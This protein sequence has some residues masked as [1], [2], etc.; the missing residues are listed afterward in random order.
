MFLSHLSVSAVFL[1]FMACLSWVALQTPFY[2]QNQDYLKMYY[3]S[4][5][6]VICNFYTETNILA[7]VIKIGNWE[8]L[9]VLREYGHLTWELV[10]PAVMSFLAGRVEQP[11]FPRVCPW[12]YQNIQLAELADN[13]VKLSLLS[14]C[15]FF[16]ILFHFFLHCHLQKENISLLRFSEYDFKIHLTSNFC[17]VSYFMVLVAYKWV[18]VFHW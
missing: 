7:R 14:P 8:T 15:C 11:F 12:N 17:I 9:N 2:H 6:G 3:F 18:S 5:C 16:S 13:V 10:F 1:F 4:G